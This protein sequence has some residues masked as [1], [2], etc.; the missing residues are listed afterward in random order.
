MSDRTI[1][2]WT[3][4]GGAILAIIG[5][6]VARVLQAALP[7]STLNIVVVVFVS[8]CVLVIAGLLAYFALRRL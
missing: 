1:W 5:V 8:L 3:I 7:S 4:V 6:I 2:N